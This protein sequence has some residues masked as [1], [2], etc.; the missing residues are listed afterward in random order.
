MKKYSV[1]DQPIKIYG[2][3]FFYEKKEFV[4][5]SEELVKKFPHLLRLSYRCA[6]VRA[7]FK[8]NAYN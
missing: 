6:G 1:F 7:A 5:L 2:I 4:R 8:T 3:P